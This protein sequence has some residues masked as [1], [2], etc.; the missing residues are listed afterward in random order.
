MPAHQFFIHLSAAAVALCGFA[1]RREPDEVVSIDSHPADKTPKPARYCS[2]SSG[3]SCCWRAG[4]RHSP[5]FVRR[6]LGALRHQRLPGGL[7]PRFVFR[8]KVCRSINP[9]VLRFS[10]PLSAPAQ[11]PGHIRLRGRFAFIKSDAAQLQQGL[12]D[13]RFIVVG[14]TRF[15]ACSNSVLA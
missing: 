15:S 9:R 2:T 5:A 1:R 13:L 7:Q 3:L 4:H 14:F 12:N 8:T 6:A 11:Q 10:M